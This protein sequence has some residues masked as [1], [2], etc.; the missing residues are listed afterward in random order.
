MVLEVLDG[1]Y[2]VERVE[3]KPD[4][5]TFSGE[6]EGEMETGR[7]NSTLKI[8]EKLCGGWKEK[9]IMKGFPF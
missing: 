5:S 8:G 2:F 3:E 4:G 7:V 9:R 1:S 6:L